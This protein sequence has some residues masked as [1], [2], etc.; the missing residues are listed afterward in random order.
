MHEGNKN[1]RR[2]HKI[3]CSCRTRITRKFCSSRVSRTCDRKFTSTLNLIAYTESLQAHWKVCGI[4]MARLSID[5]RSKIIELRSRGLAV[6]EIQR[7]LQ[8]LNISISRQAMYDLIKK[9]REKGTVK[10][11]IGRRRPRKITPEMRAAIKE[12]YNE[13]DEVTSTGIKTLLVYH[14]CRRRTKQKFVSHF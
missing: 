2:Y 9:F 6:S 8:E 12:A 1:T 4:K 14:G 13:N 3:T 10:N 7:R 11:V 5:T